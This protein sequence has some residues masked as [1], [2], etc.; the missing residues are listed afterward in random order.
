MRCTRHEQRQALAQWPE[1]TDK[2]ADS[3]AMTVISG[4]RLRSAWDLVLTSSRDLVGL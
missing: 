4:L 3:K 2:R 1:M